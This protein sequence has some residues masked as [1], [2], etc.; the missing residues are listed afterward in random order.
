MHN[1][2][3]I[4][5][6]VYFLDF[7]YGTGG[8]SRVLLTQAGIMKR[9]GYGVVVVIPN[10]EK[11]AHIPLY[12]ELCDGFKLETLMAAY[13]VATCMER[14]GIRAALE[15]YREIK[16]L[17][18]RVKPDL[19]HSV[20][21]NIAVE[22]AARGLGIPHLMNIYQADL[23]EFD[24]K[25]MDIYPHYH[26]AD[27]ELLA[28]RWSEGLGIH[29]R[30]IRVA[31]EG[32]SVRKGKVADGVSKTVR[33]LSIG[34]LAEYKN[35]MEILRFMLICKA[36]GLD[37]SLMVLGDNNNAYGKKCAEFVEQ[38]NLEK[39]VVFQGFVTN[40][41]D[42]FAQA[43]LMVLSST[44]ESYPGVVV[45]SMAN[46]VPVIS[47]PVAGIPELLRD[48]YNGFLTK[49]YRGEDIYETFLRYLAC[50]DTGRL[51][52]VT[53]HAYDC[54]L[55]NH[56]HEAVGAQLSLYYEWISRDYDKGARRIQIENVERLLKRFA[57]ERCR[58][59]LNPFTQDS[60]WL[61]YHMYIIKNSR[62][63]QRILIW[64]AGFF[65]GIALEWLEVLGCRDRLMGYIDTYKKGKY[66]GYPILEDK[67]RAIVCADMILLA[68]GD[69][70]SCL[71]SMECL[72]RHGKRRNRDYFLM[73]NSPMR[74]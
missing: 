36:R 65:G 22:L 29:S 19:V 11:G 27:S 61:L 35:Q 10:D 38:N 26:S 37:V 30:C 25:W 66:L 4:R 39:E 17:L 60:I 58:E 16:E 49:G 56:S 48:G 34:V 74:V 5:K 3:G 53:G 46:R 45:E 44:V 52:E 13:P 47:T 68:I 1:G 8:S 2:K 63:F 21:I 71:E 43:D 41:D 6:I 54:Y 33:L 7:P 50:K 70:D 28:G 69:I 31:Y 20:Q 12:D 51:S 23:E 32:C 15:S 24:I 18:E 59:G 72:E 67:E 40:V 14:I 62:P 42:Y 73:L 55:Q 9:R 64:G 57:Q